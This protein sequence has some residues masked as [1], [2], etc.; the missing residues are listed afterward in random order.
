M[1]SDTRSPTGTICPFW[2][3]T[4]LNYPYGLDEEK[5]EVGARAKKKRLAELPSVFRQ[6]Q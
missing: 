6:T 3:L 2:L 1:A 5:G 4:A